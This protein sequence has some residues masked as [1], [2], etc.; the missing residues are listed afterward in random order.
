MNRQMARKR[1]SLQVQDQTLG[2]ENIHSLEG[3]YALYALSSRHTLF[4][5]AGLSVRVLQGGISH[6]QRLIN[7]G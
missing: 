7:C 6:E 3:V 4:A 2:P 5:W 1:R